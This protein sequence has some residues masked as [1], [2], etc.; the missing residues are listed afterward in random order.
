MTTMKNIEL[1][2]NIVHYG[3][4]RFDVYLRHL[5]GYLNP[6][7][8]IHNIKRVKKYYYSQGIDDM[9]KFRNRVLGNRESGISSI[10]S[11][12][13]MGGLLVFIEYGLFNLIQKI[14][15][16]NLIEKIWQNSTNFIIY[17]II[18]LVP[19]ILINNYLLFH[20]NKYLRYFDEFEELSEKK[21]KLYSWL[22]FTTIILIIL[23]FIFSFKLL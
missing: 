6:F 13:A 17:F 16:S 8:L 22:S 15:G 10:R 9:N 11:G 21:K 12:G 23:F 5:V 3:I 4:Y 2:W 1:Y 18:L 14:T 20:K 19:V 7:K